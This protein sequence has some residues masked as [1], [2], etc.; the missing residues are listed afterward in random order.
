MV[1]AL[2]IAAGVLT[3][4]FAFASWA[5]RQVLNTDE[6]TKTSSELLEKDEIQT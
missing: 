5:N 6:W 1:T 4:L 2:L 3:F